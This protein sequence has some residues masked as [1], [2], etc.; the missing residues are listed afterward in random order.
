MGFSSESLPHSTANTFQPCQIV[1]LEQGASRLY[2]EV[3]QTVEGRQV[4]WVRPLLLSITPAEA[5]DLP[6]QDLI[7]VHDLRQGSDLLLPLVLFRSAFDLEVIPLLTHLYTAEQN[8]DQAKQDRT[9]HHQLSQFV[10]QV[11]QAHPEVF[12]A[13]QPK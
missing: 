5:I 2:A 13:G 12:Q 11:W 9:G 1:C 7:Q 3:V 8:L 10:Q 4:C 6:E